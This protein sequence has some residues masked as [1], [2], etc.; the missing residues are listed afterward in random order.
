[1]LNDSILLGGIMTHRFKDVSPQFDDTC[2]IAWNAEVT[3]DVS[4]GREVSIW[5]GASVRGDLAPITID[6]GS[7]VQ[8]N[9]VLQ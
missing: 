4:L 8:D 2:F 9:A 5:H 7:N 3:G 6:S 1:M